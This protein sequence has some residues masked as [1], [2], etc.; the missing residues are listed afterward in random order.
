MPPLTSTL[1]VLAAVSSWRR[2]QECRDAGQ[3]EEGAMYRDQARW[4]ARLA[5]KRRAGETDDTREET[6]ADTRDDTR[7]A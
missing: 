1:A 5:A 4:R 6:R 2:F 3:H 7:P